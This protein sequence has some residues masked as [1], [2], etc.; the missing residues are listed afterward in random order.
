MHRK[1]LKSQGL[2]FDRNIGIEFDRL[3]YV[4]MQIVY[5]YYLL[6]T[7]WSHNPNI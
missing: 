7:N 5:I 4:L 2:Q 3:K 6:A 1:E